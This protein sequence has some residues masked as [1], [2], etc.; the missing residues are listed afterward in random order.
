MISNGVFLYEAHADFPPP[1]CE[2]LRCLMATH[3]FTEEPL[4][5]AEVWQLPVVVASDIT[6]GKW[7]WGGGGDPGEH[8]V[9]K[10]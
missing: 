7:W 6:A 4:A 1:T 8:Q 3:H 2:S 10:Q 5:S 9:E